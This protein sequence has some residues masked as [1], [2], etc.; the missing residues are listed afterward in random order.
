MTN[1]MKHQEEALQFLSGK[2]SGGL[3]FEMGLGK[4]LIMLK[5]L[6][7]MRDNSM[8]PFPCLIICPLSVVSVWD[9]EVKKF[10]FPFVTKRLTGKYAERLESLSLD[11]DIYIINYDGAR[12]IPQHLYHR[13]FKTLILD[14]SHRIKERKS[15]Q[16]SVA[17]KLADYVPYRYI[18]TGT[19]VTRSPEDIWTQVHFVKPYH[20]DNFYSFQSKF[21]DFKKLN[22]RTKSG[23]KEV[24][25][26]YKFKNKEALRDLVA[27]VCF[28]KTKAECLDLPPKIYNPIYCS[29][30]G[31]QSKHYFKLKHTLATELEGDQIT[32]AN[33]A[34]LCQK[35][36]QVCQ[37]F[38]YDE[39]RN[40][41]FFKNNTKLTMLKDLLQD[42]Q[43]KKVILYCWFKADQDILYR[44]L[45]KDYRVLPYGGSA[46][47]REAI[48]RDFQESDSP[49]IFLSQ[50]ERAKE[51]ITL[52]ASSHI[53]YYGNS[54]SYGTRIQSEDRAHR[55]GQTKSVN[56]YDFIIP[57]TIDE[58][59][60]Y[61]LRVKKDLLDNITGDSIRLA[62]LAAGLEKLC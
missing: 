38:L 11:A 48:V 58:M 42:L 31:D 44:E 20:L 34:V 60:Y 6:E 45:S 9:N 12:L 40:P 18:L 55:T 30:E 16:T 13:G 54:W 1:L 51:G 24:R 26:A 35:L 50:I 43:D 8:S 15:I 3:F 14:E 4:T 46:S 33:A 62:R 23:M 52:T 41:L 32:T 2:S 28:R 5:H 22:I 59:I 19:P 10:G 21:V 61:A 27:Q 49:A 39:M 47:E 17:L 25:K 37:G 36:Q 56:Y 57:D 7:K 29:M 53:I